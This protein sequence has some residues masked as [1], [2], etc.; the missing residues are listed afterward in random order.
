MA[1]IHAGGFVLGQSGEHQQEL[2]RSKRCFRRLKVI[3]RCVNLFGESPA[4][5]S[6]V[7]NGVISFIHALILR[8]P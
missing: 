4:M 7:E 6:S 3:A 1:A 5:L 8:T 2:A